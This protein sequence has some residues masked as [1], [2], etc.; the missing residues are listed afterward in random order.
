MECEKCGHKLDS[1]DML[2][3]FAELVGWTED[4]E[5]SVNEGGYGGDTYNVKAAGVEDLLKR[6]RN[7]DFDTEE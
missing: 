1:V 3:E 5:F 7:A 6:A 2:R 4:E